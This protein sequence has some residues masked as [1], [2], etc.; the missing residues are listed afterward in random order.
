MPSATVPARDAQ[1]QPPHNCRLAKALP[2]LRCQAKAFN[3][4][5]PLDY[6]QQ[7]ELFEL[8]LPQTWER[9]QFLFRAGSPLG[10]IFKITSGMVAISKPLP[11]GRRQIVDF[12]LAGEICGYLGADSCYVFDGEAIT[13]VTTCSFNRARFNAFMQRNETVADAIREMLETK[14]SRARDQMAVV[15]QL[16]S[17]ERVANFLSKL[18]IAYSEHAIQTRPISLPMKRADIADY[19]GLRL[20][21]VSRAF[22]KLKKRG[23]LKIGEDEIV[24]NEVA[25]LARLSGV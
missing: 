2:C 18:S 3:V 22:S 13:D 9:R 24:I 25:L 15:G 16:S 23:I 10:P 17:T 7:K 21:T 5:K 19:L 12:H 14:L 4:C 20:E 11:D 8:G 1:R 6:D